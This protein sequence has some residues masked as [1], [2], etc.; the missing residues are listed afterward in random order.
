MPR[1]ITFFCFFLILFIFISANFRVFLTIFIFVHNWFDPCYCKWLQDIFFEQIIYICFAFY[2]YQWQTH[3]IFAPNGL[4][5]LLSI[6]VW[7]CLILFKVK[8][9]HIKQYCTSK[10]AWCY[11]WNHLYPSHS[12]SR[13]AFFFISSFCEV[14]RILAQINVNSLICSKYFNGLLF[15]SCLISV[16]NHSLNNICFYR[17]LIWTEGD[18]PSNL[19]DKYQM[20]KNSTSWRSGRTVNFYLYL[21]LFLF[22][23]RKNSSPF[24][25][26]R[27]NK[28]ILHSNVN[29]QTGMTTVKVLSSYFKYWKSLVST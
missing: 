20:F 6:M 16:W 28:I 19:F 5:A 27:Q 23:E 25:F 17:N 14:H 18:S 10:Y 12:L 21:N 24:G 22:Q 4:T 29:I 8:I 11:F 26:E 13:F 1:K 9:I 3:H 15:D 2:F 7:H